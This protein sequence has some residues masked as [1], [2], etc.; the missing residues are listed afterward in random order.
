MLEVSAVC[1]VSSQVCNAKIIFFSFFLFEYSD[2][3]IHFF[4][5]FIFFVHN[6]LF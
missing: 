3:S 2:F 5:I 1:E 6:L 4:F